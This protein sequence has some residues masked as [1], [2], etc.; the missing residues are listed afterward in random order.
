M[1]SPCSK[2]TSEGKPPVPRQA[3]SFTTQGS[4]GIRDW[5]RLQYPS[6]SSRA[7]LNT[8]M[9]ELCPPPPH[10]IYLFVYFPVWSCFFFF[11]FELL[12]GLQAFWERGWHWVLTTVTG[13]REISTGV[14]DEVVSKLRYPFV[15]QSAYQ[16]GMAWFIS[17]G[18]WGLNWDFSKRSLLWFNF[19]WNNWSTASWFSYVRDFQRS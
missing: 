5:R 10:L 1:S 3:I 13:T 6:C 11:F 4:R 18:F 8:L 17:Q 16:I 19:P 14:L 9:L 2:I 15:L 12:K 7:L